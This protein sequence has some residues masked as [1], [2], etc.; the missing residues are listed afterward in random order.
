MSIGSE[1]PEVPEEPEKPQVVPKSA[2]I[3]PAV[4][5]GEFADESPRSSIDEAPPARAQGI[6]TA[7]YVLETYLLHPAAVRVWAWTQGLVISTII[8]PASI[9]GTALVGPW[10]LLA[11][12]LAGVLA[13]RIGSRHLRRAVERF[14]CERFA[15]GLRYRHGVW[16]QS[17]TFIP[18]ARVQHTE[19]NQGPIARR[20][21]LGTLKVFTAAV[22]LGALEIDGLA[23]PD[24][25]LLRDRLLSRDVKLPGVES[26]DGQHA[27]IPAPQDLEPNIVHDPAAHDA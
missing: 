5:P 4:I 14:R 1:V 2:A 7:D 12:V 17:E 11:A 15:R 22:Q 8:V 23:Y 13:W 10:A 20:F 16:W 19:V 26:R 27:G 3:P 18:S 24:A 9:V 6:A 25:L 21:G